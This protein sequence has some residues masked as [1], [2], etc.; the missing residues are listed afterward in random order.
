MSVNVKIHLFQMDV[1][2]TTW[3]LTFKFNQVKILFNPPPPP[4][5]IHQTRRLDMKSIWNTFRQ[6]CDKFARPSVLIH[7]SFFLFIHYY[8]YFICVVILER[9][10]C[11]HSE[12][13]GTRDVVNIAVLYLF[14]KRQDMFYCVC[15]ANYFFKILFVA[16]LTGWLTIFK[17]SIKKA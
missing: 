10:A 3:Y 11:L 6:P 1:Y 8:T 12:I 9:I 4:S 15:F 5:L 17:L 13:T 16:V 2:D 7:W 14:S